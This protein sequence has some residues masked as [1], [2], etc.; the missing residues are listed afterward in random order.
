MRIGV[1]RDGMAARENFSHEMR[2][3]LGIFADQK[4]RRL[5]LEAIEQVEY[6]GGVRGRRAIIDGQPDFQLARFK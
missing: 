2:I 4:K 3:L 6:R 1:V 5:R